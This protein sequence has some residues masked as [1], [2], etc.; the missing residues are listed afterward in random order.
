MTLN[1]LLKAAT[2]GPW[3]VEG[4]RH[5][6][7]LK[8]GADTR[9]HMVG[10]DCDAVAAVF[11]DMKTGRGFMDARLIALAPDLAAAL[12]EAERALAPFSEMAG[13]MF[14]SNWNDDGVA[15]SFV[16]KNGPLR[17]TFKEFREARATLARIRAIT[18]EKE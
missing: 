18:G 12:I 16:T 5:S 2:P 13:E 8:I 7:D 15:V 6:G 9:L 1:E 4:A 10:P 3:Q 17:L 11:F 14:A